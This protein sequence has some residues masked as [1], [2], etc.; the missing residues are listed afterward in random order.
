MTHE[1][2]WDALC[3]ELE[4]VLSS[5]ARFLLNSTHCG[6]IFNSSH[7]RGEGAQGMRCASLLGT[8]HFSLGGWSVM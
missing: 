1:C 6:I 8:E 5:G 2:L 4:E 3:L 7:V